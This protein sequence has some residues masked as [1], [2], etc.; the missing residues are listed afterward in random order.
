MNSSTDPHY[1]VVLGFIILAGHL[2][3]IVI[4]V[5]GNII[6]IIMTIKKKIR[7]FTKIFL[8]FEAISD[9]IVLWF[10]AWKF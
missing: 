3:L 9:N 10:P 6:I 8:L 5:V 7:I 4:G 2:T 1:V